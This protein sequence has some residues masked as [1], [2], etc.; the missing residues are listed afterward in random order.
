MT[1]NPLGAQMLPGRLFIAMA[2][3]SAMSSTSA[4][5]PSSARPQLRAMTLLSSTM[6]AMLLSSCQ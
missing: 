1:A 5:S 3:S 2:T 4:R 6:A